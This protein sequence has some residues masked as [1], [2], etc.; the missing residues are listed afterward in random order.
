MQN[1]VI[2]GIAAMLYAVT[3]GLLGLRLSRG[4]PQWA[5]PKAALLVIALAA[6]ALHSL[7]LYQQILTPGGHNPA[8]N[9]V[10]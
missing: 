5:W 8:P 3:G 6:V 7:L 4:S 1:F 10:S 9:Q 2:G